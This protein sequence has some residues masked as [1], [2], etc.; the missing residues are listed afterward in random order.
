MS[1]LTVSNLTNITMK[2]EAAQ[3]FFSVVFISITIIIILIACPFTIG[4]NVLVI[5]AVKR[6]SRLQSNANIMLACLAVTD[7]LAGLTSQPFFVLWNTSL[8][9][10]T[11]TIAV[12]R[13]TH[14]F[15][16]AF[17]SYSSAF[18]L[19]M[20]V[21]ERLIAIKLTFL[22]PLIMTTRNIK[23][24]VCFC[25]IY[26]GWCRL[27]LYLLDESNSWYFIFASHVLFLCV[28]FVSCSYVILYFETCRHQKMIKAHQLP[29]EQ[30]ETFLK[31][32]KAL[33]TTVLVVSAVGLCLLP[34]AFYLV[35]RASG[36][37]QTRTH[38]LDS[39]EAMTRTFMLINSFLNPLIY[40]WRQ[41]E[42][43]KFVLRTS[44]EAVQPI[45]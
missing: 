12:F 4:L 20:V 31:E 2:G 6:R 40:C 36:F 27:T 45:N 11:D 32:N 7:V 44:A 22:Y 34:A 8:V 17:L 15:F 41:E 29:Q 14:R 21:G 16:F 24:A 37:F 39:M 19:M 5:T 28:V 43:R 10:G 1:N 18:H 33:K 35:I 3:H 23:I 9:F 38:L 13:A 42:M 25:W 30:M 26:S